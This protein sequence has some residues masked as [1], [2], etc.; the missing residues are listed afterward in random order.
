MIY[1]SVKEKEKYVIELRKQ[2]KT[3]REIAHELKILPREISRILKKANME[4]EEKE[5]KKTILSKTAQ[6][7]QFYK[8][9][10]SPTEV[11]IKLDLSPQEAN[12]LYQNYLSLNNLHHFEETFKE[13]D[14]SLLQEF[15]DYYSFMKENDISKK[16]IVEAIK[17]SNDY[18]K[19]KEEYNVI[20]NK[21]E[22]FREQKNFSFQITNY[23]N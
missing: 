16:E 21:L 20:F 23:W 7:L 14:K 15:I 19:I 18:P 12:S 17:I 5:R 2:E 6:A 8:R 3:Y 4:L 1:L 22:D 13:F 9:G 11:A 10:K